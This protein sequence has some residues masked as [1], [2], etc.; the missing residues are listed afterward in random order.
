MLREAASAEEVPTKHLLF[1]LHSSIYYV[2]MG[3][4]FA[5]GRKKN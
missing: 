3:R 1:L 5:A 2:K 4:L